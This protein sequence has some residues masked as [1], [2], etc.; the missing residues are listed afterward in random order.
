[1]R[2][3]DRIAV[4]WCDPGQ[5]DGAFAADGAKIEGTDA[6]GKPTGR[7]L[8]LNYGDI[9]HPPLHPNCACTLNPVISDF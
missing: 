1:M 4:G 3:K 2:S 6:N 9:A 5:V 7:A 8:S